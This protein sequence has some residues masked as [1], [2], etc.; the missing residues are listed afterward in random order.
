MRAV[1]LI[2][3]YL[4]AHPNEGCV[5]H[6]SGKA[7]PPLLDFLM[8]GYTDSSFAT[9]NKCKSFSA[10]L[11]V[12]AA[13]LVSFRTKVQSITA[14]STGEAELYALC[15]GVRQALFFLQLLDF[16][17]CKP[18]SMQMRQDNTSVIDMCNNEGCTDRTKHIEVKY[19]FVREKIAEELINLTFV[20]SHKQLADFLT[21]PLPKPAFR[22]MT[23]AAM[24]Q[25]FEPVINSTPPTPAPSAPGEKDEAM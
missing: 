1:L 2:Y 6:P 12:T 20:P 18:N 8:W 5:Y 16:L 25:V 22:F 7:V 19:W 23:K 11:F 21:K 14:L 17:G 4:K 10:Y 15:F 13:G 3:A 24:Q 9:A